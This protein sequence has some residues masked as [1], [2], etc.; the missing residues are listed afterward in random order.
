MFFPIH[1][2]GKKAVIYPNVLRKSKRRDLFMREK[3]YVK[4]SL[5]F[6][7]SI[8]SLPSC[9]IINCGIHFHLST[10]SLV[11]FLKCLC[12]FVAKLVNTYHNK[13]IKIGLSFQIVFLFLLQFHGN[14]KNGFFPPENDLKL[15]ISCVLAIN[16]TQ[17]Q[18]NKA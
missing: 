16:I 7:F 15:F 18:F 5:D 9:S 4:L 3:H 13:K 12:L 8:R 17:L 2:Q 11:F 14:R 6:D 10:T 1:I